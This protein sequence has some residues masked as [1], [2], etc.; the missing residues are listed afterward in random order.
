[1]TKLV[2]VES[3]TKAKTIRGYL[4]AGYQVEASMGHIR[5]LPASA[6]EIP[7]AHKGEPWSRLGVNVEQ[8][9]DPLYVIPSSKKKVVAQLR[10]LLKE[11]DELI[12]ATDEDREG[13][14]IGWHLSEVLKPKI[15]VQRMVFHE[16]TREA[17][18]Q[19]L[20]ETRQI[21]LDLVRAQ[22][23]RRILDRLVG[24]TVSPLL[25][26]KIAP[27]LSAGRVQSV[28]VRLLVLRE[29]ER[30]AFRSG[31]YWDLK[32][33][34]NKRPDQADHRFEAQLVSVGGVRVATGRDFDEATGK[35][36]AGKKVLLLNQE[37]TAALR[38]RLL[39][40]RWRRGGHRGEGLQALAG[41]ALHHEHASARGQP[42]DG[43]GRAGDHAHRPE[44]L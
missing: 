32:A 15:P 19:A 41:A 6:G 24:Y 5:D 11:A 22:E 25:W 28:A 23:T 18:L 14:S 38:E 9:F 34:L 40:A 31:A 16:I 43:L 17:I 42:Q 3:P 44:A 33:Q 36:P 2:I 26:K 35:I 12:L 7:E 30:R 4:P 29:R 37:Q 10:K 39:P 1:M 21:D 8:D 27:Q 13:E 20:Q